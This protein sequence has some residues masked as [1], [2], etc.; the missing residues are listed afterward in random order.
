MT[1]SHAAGSVPAAERSCADR[2]RWR[3]HHYRPQRHIDLVSIC[4]RKL[5]GRARASVLLYDKS[6]EAC[7][8]FVGTRMLKLA[9]LAAVWLGLRAAERSL[10]RFN[11]PPPDDPLANACGQAGMITV[12]LYLLCLL[13]LTIVSILTV[14]LVAQWVRRS[15]ASDQP[16]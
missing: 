10:Y 14:A 6:M 1:S 16:S 15:G 3:P 2:A 13:G 4:D 8:R 11:W 12:P 7:G 5:G 9:L